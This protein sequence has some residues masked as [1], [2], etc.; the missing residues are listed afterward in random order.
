MANRLADL[1][2]SADATRTMAAMSYDAFPRCGDC[3]ETFEDLVATDRAKMPP[4]PNCG[5][6]DPLITGELSDGLL[7]AV[8]YLDKLAPRRKI[9]GG[10]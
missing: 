8:A 5:S 1:N 7:E 9:E 10:E 4:C 3:G 6:T 2:C